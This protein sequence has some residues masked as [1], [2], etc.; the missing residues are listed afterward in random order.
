VASYRFPNSFQ[1]CHQL[2]SVTEFHNDKRIPCKFPISLKSCPFPSPIKTSNSTGEKHKCNWKK[3]YELEI[4]L[5]CTE[6][7]N[8]TERRQQSSRT[9][10][11]NN[12]HYKS[13]SCR[14]MFKAWLH[15]RITP[16]CLSCFS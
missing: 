16:N 1:E 13:Y 12:I 2:R 3:Q 15:C 4:Q 11:L 10:V 7:A 8:N 5:L 6:H 14:I 9:Q